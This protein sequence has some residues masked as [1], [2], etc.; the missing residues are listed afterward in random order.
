VDRDAARN[1]GRTVTYKDATYFF[2]SDDCRKKFQAE[3]AKYTEGG[4]ATPKLQSGEGGGREVEGGRRK[5]A[6]GKPAAIRA[7]A[8]AEPAPGE[9]AAAVVKDLVCGMDVDPK[10]PA[11][12]ARRVDYKGKA[13]FFCSDDCKAKFQT[14]PAA[15]AK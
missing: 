1:A 14:N 12:A 8:S 4:R 2:C 15:Y 6:D 13:Y 3:P 11:V 7:M 10:D 9:Q 5:A